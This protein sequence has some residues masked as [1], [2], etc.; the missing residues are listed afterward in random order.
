MLTKSIRE[1]LYNLSLLLPGNELVGVLADEKVQEPENQAAY[2]DDKK[3]LLVRDKQD[4]GDQRDGAVE[5]RR[6]ILISF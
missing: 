6:V 1:P 2:Q 3:D 4:E 5:R